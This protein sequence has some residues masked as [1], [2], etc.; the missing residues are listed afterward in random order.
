[1]FTCDSIKIISQAAKIDFGQ[2]LQKSSR[3]LLRIFSWAVYFVK[4]SLKLTYQD[5][6]I[7]RMSQQHKARLEVFRTECKKEE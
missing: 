5:N 6:D 7:A 1:M 3:L 2:L 4:Q